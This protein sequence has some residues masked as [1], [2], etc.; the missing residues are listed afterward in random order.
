[1]K[2]KLSTKT[3]VVLVVLV[4]VAILGA[5]GALIQ[6]WHMR[7]TL[8]EL[9]ST[10]VGEV[11]AASELDIALLKQSGL[12]A[13]YLLDSGN[14]RWLD[15]L[16]D[17]SPLFRANLESFRKTARHP[18]DRMIVAQIEKSFP[19]YE[20]MRD[21]VLARYRSGDPAGAKRL[22][23]QDLDRLYRETAEQCDVIVRMNKASMDEVL[24]ESRQ[25]THRFAYLVS[26]I[27]L[28]MLSL[29]T[30]LI[31][32]LVTGVFRPLQRIAHEVRSLSPEGLTLAADS[33]RQDDL[34]FLVPHLRLLMAEATERRSSAGPDPGAGLHA[35]HLATLGKTVAQVA[36]EIRNRLVVLGGFAYLIERRPED[37]EQTRDRAHTICEEVG[38][39]E[40]MLQQITEYS[41]PVELDLRGHCLNTLVKDVVAK[42]SPQVLAGIRL[43][44]SLEPELPP[45]LIDLERVE[46]V[47]INILRNAGEALGGSGTIRVSTRK[48]EGRAMVLVEDDGPGMPE[49][50]QRRIFDP[51]FTTKKR[52]TGLG[53]SV[54]KQIVIEHRGAI[55]LKSGP[56]EGAT[57]RIEFPLA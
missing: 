23:L 41:K 35:E 5:V 48:E 38:R 8:H 33:D 51:F 12:V 37:T 13:S 7:H 49:E 4:G 36:H 47:V 14:E 42:L 32:L 27:A 31:W 57:F 10:N 26:V 44:V 18:N 24:A 6:A 25:E 15:A 3:A 22:Y 20:A 43:E 53:L 2:L 30:G 9:V 29:G 56:G 39:L 16:H 46:Q 45:A 21:E 28:L 54:C 34:D 11:L 40:N 55:H 1:M 19:A 52:G 50:V 17:E